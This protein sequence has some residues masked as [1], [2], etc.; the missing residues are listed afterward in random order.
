MQFEWDERK[1]RSNISKHGVDFETAAR[2][3]EGPVLTMIDDCDDYGELREISICAVDGVVILAVVHSDRLNAI[4][5]ISARRA[6]RKE[7]EDY[8]EALRKG[9]LN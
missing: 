9:T 5:I 3:F 4:R 7:R 6:T 2:V 1:N 8:G